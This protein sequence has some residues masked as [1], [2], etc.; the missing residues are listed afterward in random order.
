MNS[1]HPLN[2]SLYAPAEDEVAFFKSQTGIDN[3]EELRSHIF[4][5]QEEAYKI[6]PY[7]CIHR[8]GFAQFNISRQPYYQQ[9]LNLGKDCKGIYVDLGCCVGTGARKA[10]MD[11]YPIKQIIASDLRPEFWEIGHKLFKSTPETFPARFIPA[12]IFD[13]EGL[14]KEEAGPVSD[15]SK[16]QSLAELRGNVSAIHA[17]ALFHLFN[18][19]EQSKLAKII[20][21]LL[22]SAPGSMIFGTQS[23]RPE[24]RNYLK[25]ARN[26]RD[27]YDMFC[28][29]PESWKSFWDGGVFPKGTVRVDASLHET[30]VRLSELMILTD[31]TSTE[32][33]YF[34]TWCIT[35]L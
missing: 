3:D 17:S 9:L 7:P 35:V 11:G 20:A 14:S 34:L 13:L 27:R 33:Y 21:S 24:G 28:H 22:S 5:I 30:A 32:N 6:Y 16:V 25:T 29:S 10:V 4:A 8:F 12:D 26:N 15:I 23:G 18:E 31:E 19:E 2:P 1:D